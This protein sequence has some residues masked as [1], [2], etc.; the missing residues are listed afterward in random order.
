VTLQNC[1][2]FYSLDSQLPV[3]IGTDSDVVVN[4]TA[5][6]V[7]VETSFLSTPPRFTTSVEAVF[8]LRAVVAGVVTA[9]NVSAANITVEVNLDDTGWID[10]RTAA[11]AALRFNTTTQSLY[12]VVDDG[13]HFL[14]ART[15]ANGTVDTSPVAHVWTVDRLSPAVWFWTAPPV[16]VTVDEPLECSSDF[17]LASNESDVQFAV[18]WRALNVSGGDNGTV[19]TSAW[20]AI[21]GTVL[22]LDGLPGS[23]PFVLHARAMDPTGNVGDTATWYWTTV[24]CPLTA[25]LPVPLRLVSTEVDDP[26]ARAIMW[27]TTD[28]ALPTVVQYRVFQSGAERGAWLRSSARPIVVTS[29]DVGAL[30]VAEVRAATPCGCGA[31]ADA[32]QTP[33]ST[34]W[35]TYGPPPGRV[36]VL[37]SPTVSTNSEF[38]L[39]SLAS[40]LRNSQLQY[41]LDGANFTG[42][43]R[44]LRLGPLSVGRHNI[45]LRS[46]D[47]DGSWSAALDVHLSWTIVSLSSSSITLEGLAAGRHSLTVFAVSTARER[48][49]RT[50]SWTVDTV[51]P[52][53]ALTLK[54]PLLTN[55]SVGVVDAT[56]LDDT[57]AASPCTFCWRVVRGF[58]QSSLRCAVTPTFSH[59]VESDGTY[60]VYAY[61]VDAAGNVGLPALVAWTRDTSPPETTASV[62][63]SVSGSVTVPALS[64]PAVKSAL[65]VVAVSAS[66]ATA[67]FILAVDDVV[68]TPSPVT[69]PSVAV[70]VYRDGMHTVSVTAVDDAGNVDP[71]PVVLRVILDT[72]T[73]VT[74]AT[75]VPRDIVNVSLIAVQYRADSEQAG[76]LSHVRLSS[77][78]PMRALPATLLPPTPES[79]VA[80]LSLNVTTSGRYVITARAVDVVGH[81]DT[82][83]V[84]VSVLVDLDPP[85][86]VLTPVLPPFVNTSVVRIGA[87]GV[88]VHSAVAVYVRVDGGPWLPADVTLNVSLAD[89]NHTVESMAVD[90]AGN[91]EPRVG[92]TSMVVDTVA[93]VVSLLSVPPP[94]S[95][96]S[97][98]SVLVAVVDA[99]PSRVDATLDGYALTSWTGNG[100]TALSFVIAPL[101]DGNHSLVLT[102][103]DDAGNAA[104]TAR[105]SWVTD[106][107]RP[108]SLVELLHPRTQ[109]NASAVT[110]SV[111][112]ALESHPE[113]CVASWRYELTPA[114]GS[115]VVVLEGSAA[116]APLTFDYAQDGMVMFSL[117]CVDA[118]GN[119]GI[120]PAILLW[121]WDQRAP[122]TTAEMMDANWWPGVSAYVVDSATVSIFA[123]SDEVGVYV[124][125]VVDG[126]TSVFTWTP[127]AVDGLSVGYHIIT[128]TAVDGA[129]N[130]DPSPAEVSVFVDTVTPSTL[131]TA[132]PPSLTN[133][134][135]V[136]FSL[137]AGKEVNGSMRG[138]HLTVEPPIAS[139]PMFVNASDVDGSVVVAV[140]ALPSSAY[141]IVA[142]AEDAAGHIDAAGVAMSFVVDTDAPQSACSH[143][144]GAYV[145]RS[146][147]TVGVNATDALSAASSFVA[148]D[149]AAWQPLLPRARFVITLPDGAHA[150]SCRAVDAAGNAQPPPYDTV[151]FVVDTIAPVVTVDTPIPAFNSLSVLPLSLSVLC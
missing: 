30:Y 39:F 40:T 131:V 147:V 37:S 135:S 143:A 24:A 33:T 128:V 23:T 96:N 26:T 93:P 103:V 75:A 62:N 34:S 70:S 111:R 74:V 117:L 28:T 148:L 114:D 9:A 76:M 16:A 110:V 19:V 124:V 66:D 115:T 49:P 137:A 42:C 3:R 13:D 134:S 80:S 141:T 53:V 89:G 112:C 2:Y 15:N 63:A 52:V 32:E 73:P 47:P 56:C 108:L 125:R 130:S 14:Q 25:L 126:P 5:P 35:F 140:S 64:L 132:A 8:T 68:V 17:V 71:S 29:L 91:V 45:T 18:Q 119:P 84:N 106:R 98:L 151:S 82:A 27:S 122:D 142:M 20:Q 43:P 11:A 54:T 6:T 78:P 36:V 22:S 86:S 127:V 21:N 58:T 4:V 46:V 87:S 57:A 133:S 109:V 60:T 31:L 77:V 102:C 121:S 12:V 44:E 79:L 95:R 144:L 41:A 104:A 59:T 67:R 94:F 61:A 139:V 97:S 145:N 99:W 65:V 116:P 50:V 123:S 150:I 1:T 72:S 69:G 51:Q 113:L 7:A 48:T 120:T 83:G 100:T 136:T 129:G 90:A 101:D 38:G 107:E 138:Y 118:A 85:Y 55:S 149:G 81:E 92:G 146:E 105:T 88:D 10:V